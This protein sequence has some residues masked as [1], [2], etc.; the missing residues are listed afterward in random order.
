M[1]NNLIVLIRHTWDGCPKPTIF[2]LLLSTNQELAFP[3][4]SNKEQLCFISIK[5]TN[6][7]NK[8]DLW[9]SRRTLK[10]STKKYY[11]L[12]A[13]FS[14]QSMNQLWSCSIFW[15]GMECLSLLKVTLTFCQAAI[16]VK[17]TAWH[18]YIHVGGKKWGS[19]L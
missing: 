4:K 16:F 2:Y 5:T 9:I 15:S 11:A 10:V 8:L 1:T 18:Q 6:W 17:V 19:D 3:D 14:L 12:N 13:N 7:G